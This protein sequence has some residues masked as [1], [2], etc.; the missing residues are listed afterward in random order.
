MRKLMLLTAVV[1]FVFGGFALSLSTAPAN[2]SGSGAHE[3]QFMN[4]EYFPKP[5][6]YTHVVTS[7]PGRMIFLSGSGGHS[8]NGKLPDDFTTQAHNVFK[9]LQNGLKMA[10]ATFKDVVKITYFMTNINDLTKL[11][12]VRENYLNMAAPPAASAVETGL[13]GGMLLEVELIA[14]VPE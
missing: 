12:Q 3:K 7:T 4:L 11:R 14:I 5:S 8:P 13:S 2:P 1:A 10:G 6:G 9:N